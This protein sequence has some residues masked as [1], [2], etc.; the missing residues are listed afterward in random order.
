MALLERFIEK[1][2]VSVLTEEEVYNG[3]STKE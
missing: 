1:S 2:C 3:F